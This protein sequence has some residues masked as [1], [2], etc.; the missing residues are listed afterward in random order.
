MNKAKI[1]NE[2]L[3]FV[4]YLIKTFNLIFKIEQN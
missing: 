3:I 2:C 4:F 1:I